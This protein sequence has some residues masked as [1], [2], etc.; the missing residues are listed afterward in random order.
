M[1]SMIASDLLSLVLQDCGAF[2][3]G[4]SP[5]AKQIQD[6]LLRLN[7]MLGQWQKKRGLVYTQEVKSL[8]STGAASYTVG[9]GG[10]FPFAYRPSKIASAFVRIVPTSGNAVDYPLAEVHSREDYSR[11]ALK[12]L[13]SFPTH[14]F[15]DNAYPLGHI[16]PWPVPT[17]AI[18][19][20]HITALGA[21][22]G[23]VADLTTVL[24]LPDE[25]Y[26]AL[27]YNLI[28]RHYPVFR[29]QP[30]PVI[31]QLARESLSTIRTANAQIPELRMPGALRHSGAYNVYSDRGR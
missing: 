14:Y 5:S 19:Q 30:D 12:S 16:Y 29:I 13:T 11:I 17:G 8:T 28:V 7:M 9:P 25:Y 31:V 22:L 1:P 20:L 6:A 27:Y 3:I 24:D 2:G 21:V 26:N 4:Q 18:Y 23:A 10:D 15:Y